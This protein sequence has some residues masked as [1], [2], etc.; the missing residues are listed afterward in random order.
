MARPQPRSPVR[1]G[2]PL[3]KAVSPQRPLNGNGQV[4]P[5]KSTIVKP[6]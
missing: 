2:V 4:A 3:K 6:L 5:V 1:T